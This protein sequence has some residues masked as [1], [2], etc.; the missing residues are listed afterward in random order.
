MD[1]D[2]AH[3]NVLLYS[4]F[5]RACN[6]F[7]EILEKVPLVEENTTLV[8]VDNNEV[9][10]RIMHSKKLSIKEVP[11]LLRVYESNGYVESFEG[12]KA[13]AVLNAHYIEYLQQLQ[14]QEA[15][16]KK[17]SSILPPQPPH[18]PQQA[19][20]SQQQNMMTPIENITEIDPSVM[21]SMNN[22]NNALNTY[23]H[24][25]SNQY[26]SSSSPPSNPSSSSSS[27]S[28][29]TSLPPVMSSVDRAIKKEAGASGGGGS[30]VN[31]AMQMQKERE[32]E[33]P[34]RPGMPP[35][36]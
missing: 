23:L 13:F 9:R 15:E 2:N 12:E 18:P 4:K 35:M 24:I 8:C 21:N 1:S 11:A 36:N 3:I 28:S 25:P 31:L 7:L 16:Q 27:S 10:K 34:S 22:N 5:S 19:V 33:A 26:P 32:N 20:Q 6:K 29:S 17:A 30:I 14:A